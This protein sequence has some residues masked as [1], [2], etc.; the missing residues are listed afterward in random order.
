MRYMHKFDLDGIEEV[1]VETAGK[2][3]IH[4]TGSGCAGS[5]MYFREQEHPEAGGVAFRGTD[6]VQC[7][8][9]QRSESDV[10]GCD[11]E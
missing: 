5:V 4:H 9:V 1:L 11:V 2:T 3:G 8:P 10:V 7:E 6:R